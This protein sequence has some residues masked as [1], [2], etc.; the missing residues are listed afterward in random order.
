M[1]WEING[2]A[3]ETNDLKGLLYHQ[4]KTMKLKVKVKG[5]LIIYI[6]QYFS[7][8]WGYKFVNGLISKKQH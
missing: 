7:H 1:V 3:Y 5:N 2:R 6:L 8:L 4:S